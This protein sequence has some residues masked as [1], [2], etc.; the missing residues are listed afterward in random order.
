ML[1]FLSLHKNSKSQR[2]FEIQELNNK[3]IHDLTGIERE[4]SKYKKLVSRLKF[5]FFNALNT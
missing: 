5:A 4:L 3:F 2:E 1:N